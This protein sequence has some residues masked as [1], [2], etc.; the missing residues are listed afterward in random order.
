MIMACYVPIADAQTR[1]G[2][3]GVNN[4]QLIEANCMSTVLRNE[5]EVARLR[6]FL[7][8]L[9]DCNVNF[10]QTFDGTGCAPLRSVE[11]A[12]DD[13]DTPTTLTFS[14]N[15][16]NFAPSVSVVRGEP[17]QD[18]R[19]PNDPVTGPGTGPS[20]PVTPD[21][22]EP[23]TE[24]P[25][26]PVPTYHAGCFVDTKNWDQTSTDSDCTSDSD[27]ACTQSNSITWSVGDTMGNDAWHSNYPVTIRWTGDCTGSSQ[28]CNLENVSNGSYSA[29]ATVTYQG[30]QIYRRTI[31]ARKQVRTCSPDGNDP[32]PN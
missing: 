4:D 27:S 5:T 9:V 3:G 15:G 19:C 18:A 24:P 12:W 11:H 21:P 26:D 8:R 1:T 16:Y 31:R 10:G 2:R 23:P 13:V 14:D 22:T 30:D 7:N 29:T 20:G 28:W 32:L 25:A 6:T 17:G